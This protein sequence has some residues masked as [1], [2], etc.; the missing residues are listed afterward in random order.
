MLQCIVYAVLLSPETGDRCKAATQM[1]TPHENAQAAAPMR[2]AARS[3]MTVLQVLTPRR[4]EK[5]RTRAIN[6]TNQAGAVQSCAANMLNTLL[7]TTGRLHVFHCGPPPRSA[8]TLQAALPLYAPSVLTCLQAAAHHD[9]LT[10]V[11]R[12][13]QPRGALAAS[14][15]ASSTGL[16][17]RR[18]RGRGRRRRR[19]GRRRRRRLERS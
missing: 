6:S 9:S 8:S 17:H 18:R 12:L 7:S 4:H 2:H 5:Q 19:R 15:L 14:W 1:P 10:S 3:C 16:R 11:P 13:P